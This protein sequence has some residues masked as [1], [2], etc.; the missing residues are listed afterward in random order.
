[1]E[2]FSSIFGSMISNLSKKRAAELQRLLSKH[3]KKTKASVSLSGELIR[4]TDALA[5]KAQRSAFVERAVR[6]YLHAILRRARH[7]HDLQAI[8]AQAEGTNRESDHLLELQA[9]PE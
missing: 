5:G 6:Q 3:E 1:M 7:E 4:A 2:Y 9:W 8:A